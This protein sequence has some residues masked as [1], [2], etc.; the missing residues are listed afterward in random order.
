LL[1]R[2]LKIPAKLAFLLY[3]RSAGINHKKY[4]AAEGPLLIAAN[5]P[6]SFLDA[7]IIATLFKRPVYSLTRGDVYKNPFFSK[8]LNAL[9]MLPVYRM[10]EGVENLEQNYDTFDKCKEI[11]KKNGIVLIFS[12]GRCINEWRLRPLKKGTARL[13]ISSWQD[14]INLKVLPAGINYQSFTVFGK[15][16]LL[17]FGDIINEEDI[18]HTNGYGK[19]INDFNEKLRKELTPLITEA[20][21]DDKAFIRNEFYV[22][23]NILKK[24]LLF[25]PA[26]AGWVTHAPLFIPVRKF[27][28]KKAG[29]NDHYDSMLVALLFGTYPLY[30]LLAAFLLSLCMPGYWWA[31]VFI[32][33]P[34]FAWS[35][36][37]LKHQF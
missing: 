11:F 25:I 7:V 14:G 18:D 22:R 23:Q 15:N 16:V 19:T 37:Q 33:M 17:N 26:V 5:H 20:D 1:Y 31:A 4:L 8:I 34:F 29:H 2:L 24:I 36:V 27:S 9:K 21:K 6:N 32:L 30:L 13:A 3:C 28:R 12:E 10:S 35:Y